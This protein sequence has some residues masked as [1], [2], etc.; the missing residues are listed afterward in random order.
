MERETMAFV[1]CT[2]RWY[3]LV[4]QG[5]EEEEEENCSRA[6]HEGGL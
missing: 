4:E 5:E 2:T 1:S 3:Y 6:A